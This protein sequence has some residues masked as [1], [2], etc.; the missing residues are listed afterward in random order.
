MSVLNEVESLL[1]TVA[2]LSKGS[3]PATPDNTV[4]LYSTGGSPRSLSGT[5]VEEPT[6][7]VRVRNI[8]YEAGEAL[9]ETIA[10]LLHG[11]STDNLLLIQQQSGIL[12]LGRDQ[13]NRAEFTINF[14]CYYRK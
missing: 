5:F 6:F 11:K 8:S 2:D 7:Q 1:P 13:N 9:C 4:C 10:G 12:P 14:R 3:M